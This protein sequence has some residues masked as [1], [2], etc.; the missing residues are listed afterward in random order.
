MPDPKISIVCLPVAGIENPYQDL[1]IEGLNKCTTLTAING[2][3]DRFFG[4]FKSA[5]KYQ[6]DY[7][8]FDWIQSYY[9]RRELWMT[10]LLLPL[11][12]LQV[13]YL[14]W[15]TKTQMV[16]TLHNILPHNV[17]HVKLHKWVRHFFA[18]NCA[19]VRVFSDDSVERA[20]QI[21]KIPV[22]KF[23]VIP[24][25][26]YTAVYQNSI[27]QMA[28]RN[29]LGLENNNLV[30]LYLGF[31]KPYKGI[32]QLIKDFHLIMDPNI[33]LLI[34]GQGIDKK[35]TEKI[36]QALMDLGDDRIELKDV[37]ISVEDLQLYYN[38]SDLVVLPFEKIENSGS[39]IMAMGY[40]KAVL[41]PKMGVLSARLEQQD[42]LL[43]DSL[44]VGLK[45]ALEM[46][47]K[48]LEKMGEL[49]FMALKKYKWEDFGKAFSA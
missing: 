28:A 9:E 25:G 49:N 1:M 47:K 17:K 2:I 37:F 35:Y 39:A 12:I 46:E 44:D 48:E 26:D 42:Y 19:W 34:A 8:H 18:S 36:K 29:I 21:L 31:I 40:K 24:E 6:P 41:A 10:L 13:K 27:T 5:K 33:R 45:R 4:I 20:S 15:F 32:E 7:M 30:M 16:W 3:D 22:K 38:A 11:F 23:K 14:R 43:Y